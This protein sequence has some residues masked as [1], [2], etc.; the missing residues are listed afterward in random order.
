MD[1]TD[2]LSSALPLVCERT[3]ANTTHTF[4]I[5][6]TEA[7]HRA[8]KIPLNEIHSKENLKNR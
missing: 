3:L 8:K 4:L 7:R 1:W 6:I 2:Q 5:S